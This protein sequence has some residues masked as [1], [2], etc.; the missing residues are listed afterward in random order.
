MVKK[1]VFQNQIIL[2]YNLFA[3]KIFNFKIKAK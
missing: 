2:Y 3:E 1:K